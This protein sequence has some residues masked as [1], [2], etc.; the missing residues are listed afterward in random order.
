[1]KLSHIRRIM[2]SSHDTYPL[3]CSANERR[4]LMLAKL[5]GEAKRREA[6]DRFYQKQMDDPRL[7][8]FFDGSD[9]EIIKWHQLC[10]A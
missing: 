2:A 6:I 5:G 1:M 9:V 8:R 4:R 7:V 3:H 10:V